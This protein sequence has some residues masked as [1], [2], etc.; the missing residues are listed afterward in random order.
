MLVRPYLERLG[1]VPVQ[2]HASALFKDCPSC[3]R[4][5]KRCVVSAHQQIRRVDRQREGEKK[6][7]AKVQ[8]QRKT[9]HACKRH[10]FC[11]ID[12]Q[13]NVQLGERVPG[14]F[15]SARIVALRYAVPK[16][17]RFLLQE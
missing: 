14:L 4:V 1:I 11:G 17:L 8:Q 16:V 3:M 13:M 10:V 5:Y 7:S 9:V 12:G 6:T 15:G 2:H